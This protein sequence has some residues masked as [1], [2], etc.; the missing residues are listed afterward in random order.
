MNFVRFVDATAS[1]QNETK[2]ALYHDDVGAKK[3]QE[4]APAK[5]GGGRIWSTTSSS[6]SECA[7]APLL[8]LDC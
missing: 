2:I 5:E 6:W 7:A 4:R 3:E 8:V 1:N